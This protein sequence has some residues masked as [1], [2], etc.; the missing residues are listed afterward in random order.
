MQQLNK[1]GWDDA[2]A[3]TPT[4]AA[5]RILVAYAMATGYPL[6][7]GDIGTAFLH[8]KIPEGDT[9]LVRP[10]ITERDGKVWKLKKAL[11]T[12]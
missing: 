9:I 2:Y 10:P 3:A 6:T 7:P 8:A 11:S 1:G 12:A 4:A 5:T